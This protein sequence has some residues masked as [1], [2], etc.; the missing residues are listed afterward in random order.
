[1][2]AI[3]KQVNREMYP[4]LTLVLGGA[5]SGKSAWAEK[6]VTS[7]GASRVY[8]A[9]AQPLDDEMRVKISRH[10]Q[11]R[12]K[13]WRTV[14]EPLNVAA[15]LAGVPADEVILFDCATLWLSNHMFADSDLPDETDRLLTALRDCPAPVVVVSNE[16]GQ[17]IVPADPLSR[18]FREEQGRLNIRLA[19][20]ARLV[21]FVTAG[22]ARV[23]KGQLPEAMR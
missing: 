3:N 11:R 1:M 22:L 10:Q 4:K 5:A 16:V 14:E 8:L 2:K 15:A 17:G 20:A 6:L 9:S 21:V 13:G 7:S 23:L 12:D 18:R 19:E